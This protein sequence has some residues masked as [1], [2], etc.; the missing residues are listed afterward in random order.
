MIWWLLGFYLLTGLLAGVAMVLHCRKSGRQGPID[1][2]IF[3]SA[4][5]PDAL[6]LIFLL[7]L[8]PLVLPIIYFLPDHLRPSFGGEVSLPSQVRTDLLDREGIVGKDLRPS[9]TII[10]DGTSHEATSAQGFIPAG[11]PVTVVDQDS[12]RVRVQRS[13]AHSP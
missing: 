8:W 2:L 6:L 4:L 10:I 3:A 5:A 12:L 1:T 13:T 9:G 11:T 7:P